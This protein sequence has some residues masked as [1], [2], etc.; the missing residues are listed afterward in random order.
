MIT[1]R[2]PHENIAGITIEHLLMHTGGGSND[3]DD[4]MFSS[5]NQR[6][7]VE[8]GDLQFADANWSF[9]VSVAARD[10]F[11]ASL[12]SAPILHSTSRRS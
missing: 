5:R 7:G 11:D 1:R 4:P 8:Q 10:V 9:R 6:Q 3:R 2:T 12:R